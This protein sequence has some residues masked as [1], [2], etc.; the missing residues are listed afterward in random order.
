MKTV[1]S[2]L[3]VLLAIFLG[4]CS[5]YIPAPD[6]NDQ[7]VTSIDTPAPTDAANSNDSEYGEAAYVESIDTVFLESFPLQVHAVVKGNL[8]DGCTT[9]Q[10][11]EIKREGDTF[12]ITIFTQRQKGAFCTEAL[13]PFEYIVALDV[14]G[15]PAG[16]YVIKAYDAVAEFMFSQDNILQE[17]G[18]G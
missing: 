4:A 11:H 5:K 6:G 18:G 9:I 17:S 7:P 13:V 14:Y 16:K 15:L 10:R 12:T 3:F 8:P 2:I 1:Y